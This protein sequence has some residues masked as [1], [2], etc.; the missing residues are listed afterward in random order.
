VKINLKIPP[1]VQKISSG[2]EWKDRQMDRQKKE[3]KTIN[4][5]VTWG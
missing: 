2:E 1:G 5:T 3:L 4:L